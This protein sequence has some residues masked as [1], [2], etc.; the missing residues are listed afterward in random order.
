MEITI[1]KDIKNT[2]QPVYREVEIVLRRIR[3]GASKEL[4]KNIRQES[5]KSKRNLINQS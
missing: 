1:I 2:S 5:D 4:V 3:E